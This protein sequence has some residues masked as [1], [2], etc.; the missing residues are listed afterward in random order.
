MVVLLMTVWL[1][2]AVSLR[3]LIMLAHLRV[4]LVSLLT[5]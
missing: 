2:M 1:M 4:V 3:S 5:S